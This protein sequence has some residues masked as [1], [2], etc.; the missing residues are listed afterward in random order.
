MN[1]NRVTE[2]TA[3]FMYFYKN[4]TKNPHHHHKFHLQEME[5]VS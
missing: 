2:N 5:F 3:K 4:E 1:F